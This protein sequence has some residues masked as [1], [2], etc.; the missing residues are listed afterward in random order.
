MSNRSGEKAKL[1]WKSA[2]KFLRQIMVKFTIDEQEA[3]QQEAGRWH[4]DGVNRPGRLLG[5]PGVTDSRREPSRRISVDEKIAILERVEASPGSRR[6]MLEEL[7]I[8]ESTYYRWRRMRR[9]GR[10]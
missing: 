6:Q 9:Q 3:D 1:V 10:L 8:P 2:R 7:G 4:D 5:E